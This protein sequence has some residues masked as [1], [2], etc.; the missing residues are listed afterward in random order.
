MPLLILL[1]VYAGTSAL[2]LGIRLGWVSTRRWRWIHHGLFALIW[3]ALGGVLAWAAATQTWPPA[4]AAA[5]APFLALLPRFRPGSARH[6]WT[7]AGGLAV[8]I[9]SLA[10]TLAWR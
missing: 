10:L 5:S 6:C 9:V 7:A 1:A 4:T 2:G 3:L 8:V